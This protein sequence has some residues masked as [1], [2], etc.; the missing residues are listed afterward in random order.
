[1]KKHAYAD[2]FRLEGNQLAYTGPEPQTRREAFAISIAKWETIKDIVGRGAPLNFNEGG[3]ST[4]GLCLLYMNDDADC[5]ACCNA[6]PIFVRTGQ[7]LC[8]RT[9]FVDFC[10]MPTA[11]NAQLE[12]DFLRDVQEKCEKEQDSAIQT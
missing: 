10:A 1:M 11:K 8:R 12:I 7:S 2:D 9:P 4:C 5:H 6:C 3:T